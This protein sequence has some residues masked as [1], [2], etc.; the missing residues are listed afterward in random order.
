MIRTVS[1][2]Y[3]DSGKTRCASLQALNYIEF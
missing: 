3:R 2:I 1:K